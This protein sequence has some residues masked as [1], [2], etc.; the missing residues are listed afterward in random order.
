MCLH[1]GDLF[2]TIVNIMQWSAV[3]C[4]MAKTDENPFSWNLCQ[5][6]PILCNTPLPP[7]VLNLRCVHVYA[8]K[9]AQWA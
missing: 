3:N 8:E 1:S 2:H 9:A 4:I 7:N 5:I 6:P